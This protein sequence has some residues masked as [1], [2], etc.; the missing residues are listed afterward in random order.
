MVNQTNFDLTS[1]SGVKPGLDAALGEVSANLEQFLAAPALNSTALEIAHSELKHLSGAL[2]MVH[3]DGVVVFCTELEN[4][5]KELSADPGIVSA[6][7]RDVLRRTLLALTHYL[8]SLSRGA[9]NIS[10]RLFPQYQELQQLRGLEMAFE[11]DLFFLTPVPNLNYSY[12]TH[13]FPRL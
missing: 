11:T 6:L 2:I 1:F 10:L 7:H 13:H 4:V 5:L 12:N 3:L 9:E 8:D